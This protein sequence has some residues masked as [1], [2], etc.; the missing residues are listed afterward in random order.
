MTKS[1]Q[2]LG[3]ELADSEAARALNAELEQSLRNI[4]AVRSLPP[5]PRVAGTR[6]L[7]PA[8]E[9]RRT[10]ARIDAIRALPLRSAP[11]LTVIAGGKHDGG[12]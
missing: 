8:A 4:A 10:V 11:R 1:P 5:S 2:D 9:L 12:N 3:R 7:D 6:D